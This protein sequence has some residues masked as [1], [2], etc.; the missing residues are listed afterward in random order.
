MWQRNFTDWVREA[1]R[2]Y[3]T[4]WSPDFKSGFLLP[5]GPGHSNPCTP[6][7]QKKKRNLTPT[8]QGHDSLT[9]L[10]LQNIR[11]LLNLKISECFWERF[12]LK[13]L[14]IEAGNSF[15]TIIPGDWEYQ[16]WEGQRYFSQELTELGDLN[17]QLSYPV[18]T[19]IVHNPGSLDAQSLLASCI[20]HFLAPL[21]W[22]SVCA[23]LGSQR[24]SP[25]PP[26]PN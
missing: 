9:Q 13:R 23:L 10:A 11:C 24:C 17:P 3:M 2:V 16:V 26:A 19:E 1:Q 6:A 7:C 22:P 12:W 14:G 18:C 20:L 21:L 5:W 8:A 4:C 15:L 25:T